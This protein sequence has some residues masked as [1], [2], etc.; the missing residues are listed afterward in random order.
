MRTNSAEQTRQVGERFARTLAS[1]DVVALAGELGAGKTC[2][3][4]GMARSAGVSL[5]AFVRS[6]SFTILNQY[7]GE[8]FTLYHLDFYR[9]PHRAALDDMG[10]E[11]YF[12]GN[13]VTVVEWADMFPHALP[14]RALWVRFSIVDEHSRDIDLPEMPAEKES[15]D[16]PTGKKGHGGI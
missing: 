2:F 1:G 5:R 16:I 14:A 10:L 15:A 4:Q 3:V 6:P 8:R 9:I 7:D 11:E 13:G 12:D